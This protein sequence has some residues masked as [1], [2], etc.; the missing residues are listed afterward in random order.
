MRIKKYDIVSD[1]GDAWSFTWKEAE[2]MVGGDQGFI[3][4]K[5]TGEIMRPYQYYL[6]DAAMSVSEEDDE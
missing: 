1:L 3:V 5:D 2:N 4:M 6:E